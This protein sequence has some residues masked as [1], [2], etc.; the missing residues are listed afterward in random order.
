VIPGFD[1]A[2]PQLDGHPTR[3]HFGVGISDE[4]PA[5]LPAGAR[6]RVV[7]SS[8]A[9]RRD[10]ALFD[11]LAQCVRL[12]RVERLPAETTLDAMSDLL[13]AQRGQPCDLLLAVGGGAAMDAAKVL[14]LGLNTTAP[15][16]LLLRQPDHYAAA[17]LPLVCVPTTSGTGSDVTPYATLWDRDANRKRS[18]SHPVLQPQATWIDP[19]LTLSLPLRAT[20][21]SGLDALAHALEAIWGR[22]HGPETDA[23]A[24]EA[25]ALI[26]RNLPTALGTPDDLGARTAMARAALAAGLAICRT[27]TAAAH[28]GS[29]ALTLRYGIAH[30]HACAL[31]LPWLLRW[32]GGTCP[33]RIALV[34]EAFGVEDADAA[35]RTVERLIALAGLPSRLREIG[36][37]RDALPQLVDAALASERMNNTVDALGADQIEDLFRTLW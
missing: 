15:L 16:P 2:A 34:T 23:L 12:T 3:I 1:D 30:G 14:A 24:V 4:L 17:A 36:V 27:Q 7:A 9:R 26:V 37:T 18:L 13:D 25:A 22:H 31:S 35:A 33:Q 32:H 10:A 29:Y 20:A 8:G 21:T 28:A 19:V 5:A 6:V 11:T